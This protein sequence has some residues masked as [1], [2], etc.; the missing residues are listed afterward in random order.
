MYNVA[1]RGGNTGTRLWRHVVAIHE[2]AD[3]HE[4]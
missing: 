1:R 4:A 3:T 2:T